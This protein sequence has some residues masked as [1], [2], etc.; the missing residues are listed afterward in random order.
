MAKIQTD[1]K[2]IETKI[3]IQKKLTKP[4]A[5]SLRKINKIEKPPD[6]LTKVNRN[7]IQMYK[8]K[9]QRARYNNRNRKF[10][11]LEPTT[12]DDTQQ[13]KKI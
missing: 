10:K 11:K 2:R 4:K 3:M 6:E 1:V 13:V 5:G 8:I 9:Q 7:S 12:K